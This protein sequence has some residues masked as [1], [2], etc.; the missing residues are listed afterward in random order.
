MHST[1]FPLF[2]YVILGRIDFL[3]LGFL[4]PWFHRC[5]PLSRA[6]SGIRHGGCIHYTHVG[7]PQIVSVAPPDFPL[8]K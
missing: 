7:A 6:P 4:S 2:T 5:C 8:L 3:H 1:I